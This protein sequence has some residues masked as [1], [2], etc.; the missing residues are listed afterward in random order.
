MA[1]QCQKCQSYAMRHVA[2]QFRHLGPDQ[3]FHQDVELEH[4]G[5]HPWIWTKNAT[6]LLDHEFTMKT[7]SVLQ[8]NHDYIIH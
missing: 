5:A 6:D 4:A 2:S 7:R 3:L 1:F 8:I